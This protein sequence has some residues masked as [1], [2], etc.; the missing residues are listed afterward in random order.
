MTHRSLSSGCPADRNDGKVDLRPGNL[1]DIVGPDI[2][3]DMLDD[4]DD[5]RIVVACEPDGAEILVTDMA[6]VARNL[7]GETHRCGGLG[8]VGPAAAIGDHLGI[9]KLGEV[10]AEIGVGGKAVA[11]AIDLGDRQSDALARRRGK[12]ALGKRSGQ[13]EIAFQRSRAIGNEPEEVWDDAELLLDGMQYRLRR[14]RRGLYG[15]GRRDTGHRH[16]FP[17]I[18]F[19]AKHGPFHLL[20]LD[21]IFATNPSIFRE[22]YGSPRGHVAFRRRGGGRQPF[23]RRTPL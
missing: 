16:S 4:L 3:S 17:L 7:G 5:L 13:S 6:A 18:S 15:R 19:A 22:K 14:S 20:D 8:V 11:A 10:L 2:E 23:G 21:V 12:A 9:V 1:I